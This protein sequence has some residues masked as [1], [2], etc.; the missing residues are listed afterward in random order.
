MLIRRPIF[1]V[2]ALALGACATTPR[3]HANQVVIARTT[4]ATAVLAAEI[5]LHSTDAEPEAA[6][7][8]RAAHGIAAAALAAWAEASS[9]D[10]KAQAVAATAAALQQ[11]LFVA[12]AVPADRARAVDAA[13][14]ATTLAPPSLAAADR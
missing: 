1:A 14:T 8:V 13:A 4:A 6:I 2:I 3:D 10:G 5:Y 11:A 12:L 9:D 7:A